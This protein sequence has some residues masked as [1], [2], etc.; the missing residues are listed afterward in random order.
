MQ[1]F[2][3]E[4]RKPEGKSIVGTRVGRYDFG[5]RNTEPAGLHLHHAQQVKIL[6]IQKHRR[7]GSLFKQSRSAYVVDMRM[8]DDDLPQGEAM[9][10]QPGENFWDII[11]GVND[12]G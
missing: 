4:G 5:R 9:L 6:L 1:Y 3:G 8:G 12:H 2:G 7:A 10:R 11:P